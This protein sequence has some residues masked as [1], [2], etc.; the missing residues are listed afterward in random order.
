MPFVGPMLVGLQDK[1]VIPAVSSK[2][3]RNP[4]PN[5][6]PQCQGWGYVGQTLA[7]LGL[8]MAPFMGPKWS[9]RI[10]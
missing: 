7:N 1:A 9:K 5:G 8:Y 6:T 3:L 4:T 2:M 10:R